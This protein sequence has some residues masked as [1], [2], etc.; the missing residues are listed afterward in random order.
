MSKVEE[1]GSRMQGKEM[2]LIGIYQN[3]MTIK[4]TRIRVLG[5]TRGRQE[6]GPKA[7]PAV[8]EIHIHH[9][10]GYDSR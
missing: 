9:Y 2:E 7:N 6:G 8:Y 10:L 5:L 3:W 4:P 1:E